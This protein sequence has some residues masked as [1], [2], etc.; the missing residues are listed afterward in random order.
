MNYWFYDLVKFVLQLFF[1]LGFGLEVSGREH[2]PKRGAFIVAANHV[3]FLDP[4]LVGAVCPRRLRFLART[5]LYRRPLLGAFLRGVHAIPLQRDAADL[6][7]M[8]AALACLRR[9]EA[10]TIFP[11]GGR[12]C[13]GELG[14][15][16]RGVGLLADTAR[17]PIVPALVEGTFQALPPGARRLRR[18]KIRV[19]F[20][21]PIPYTKWS[22]S[23]SRAHHEELAD[24]VTRRWRGLAERRQDDRPR[25]REKGSTL[26][27]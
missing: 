23:S 1:R 27:P 14:V 10:V 7:A 9:G 13:S 2:V 21:E 20:G 4:P 19:A 15:A 16:K 3:S 17:A 12:Q 11:E 18:A 26:I 6:A 22:S 8:R 24:A 5:D 25:T